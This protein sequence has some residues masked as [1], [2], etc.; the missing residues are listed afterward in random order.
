VRE[1]LGRAFRLAWDTLQEDCSWDGLSLVPAFGVEDLLFSIVI[2]MM[3]APRESCR[4]LWFE[5]GFSA[6]FRLLP[7]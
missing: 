1:L 2:L 4:K 3:T 7:M 5:K 6:H